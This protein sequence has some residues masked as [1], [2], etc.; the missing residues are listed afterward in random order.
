MNLHDVFGLDLMGLVGKDF[1]ALLNITMIDL[2]LAGDNAIVVGMAASRVDP[3]MRSRVIFWGMAIAVV[4]RIVFAL[5]TAQLLVIVGL[6]LAGGILLLWVC[7]KMYREIITPNFT[8]DTAEAPTSGT[9]ATD[10]LATVGFGAALM[11]IILADVS[12]SLDNVLAVAG[13]AKGNMTVLILGLALAVLFMAVAANYIAKLLGRFPGIMW[14]GLLIIL[15]V[16]IDMIWRGSHE[17]ACNT[18]GG[19]WCNHSLLDALKVK[20]GMM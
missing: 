13:A 1:I 16:S 7:W 19:Y 20:A 11:H 5:I 10:A 8:G 3:A 18:Y 14:I 15:Y 6:T 4:L 2:V 12:M 9:D 17:V